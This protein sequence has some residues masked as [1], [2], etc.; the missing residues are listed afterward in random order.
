MSKAVRELPV[1][2]T[3]QK[4]ANEALSSLNY[5]KEGQS[6]FGKYIKLVIPDDDTGTEEEKRPYLTIVSAALFCKFYHSQSQLT[7]SYF[8]L[9]ISNIPMMMCD[10]ATILSR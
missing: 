8:I 2:K 7:L 5:L 3:A 9:D 10:G 4:A 1:I 6:W